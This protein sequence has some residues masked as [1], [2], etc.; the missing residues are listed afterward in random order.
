MQKTTKMKFKRLIALAINLQFILPTASFAKGNTL[1]TIMDAVGTVGGAY[2]QQMQQMQMQEYSRRQKKSLADS[3]KMT[4]VDPNQVPKVFS[5]NGCI[6]VKARSGSTSDM[7]D[8]NKYDPQK[9]QSGYYSALQEISED[10]LEEMKNFLTPGNQRFTTQGVGCFDKSIIQFN[11]ELKLRMAALTNLEKSIEQFAKDFEVDSQPDLEEIK[12]NEALLTGTPAEYLK[13]LK[14]EDEFKDKRCASVFAS[15]QFKSA[16]GKGFNAIETLLNQKVSTDGAKKFDNKNTIKEIKNEIRKFATSLSNSAVTTEEFNVD[17][18]N[19]SIRSVHLDIKNTA[20]IVGEINQK[21]QIENA[22]QKKEIGKIVGSDDSNLQKMLTD[23]ESDSI[24]DL[25]NKIALYERDDNNKCLNGLIESNFKTYKGVTYSSG[26][27]GLKEAIRDPSL[28]EKMNREADSGFE[29]NLGRMLLD[30]N[31]TIEMKLELIKRDS[32]NNNK[33][34]LDLGDSGKIS[35]RSIGA[36]DKLRTSDMIGIFVDNCK[37]IFNKRRTSSGKS[38]KNILKAIKKYSSKRKSLK[39]KYA[40]DL[41]KQIIEKMQ[42]CPEQNTVGDAPNS[43]DGALKMS[44]SNFC[45]KSAVTCSSNMLACQDKAK[46]VVAKHVK[47]QKA[48]VDKYVARV[49]A[50]KFNIE[51]Q[52]KIADQTLKNSAQA[53]SGMHGLGVVYEEP[54]GL[55]MNRLKDK[56]LKGPEFYKELKLEDPKEYLKLVKE[57]IKNL[58]EKV[59]QNHKDLMN[60]DPDAKVEYKGILG[61]SDKYKKNLQDENQLWEDTAKNCLALRNKFDNEAAA[62]TAKENEAIAKSNEEMK[63]TCGKI[64]DFEEHPL[65]F[66]GDVSGF[67]DEVSKISSISEGRSVANVRQFQDVCDH[68]ESQSSNTNDTTGSSNYKKINTKGP[69]D[70][71]MQAVN[72]DFRPCDIVKNITGANKGE[73]LCIGNKKGEEIKNDLVFAFLQSDEGKEIY[74]KFAGK[75]VDKNLVTTSPETNG[76]CKES[77]DIIP[78]SEKSIELANFIIARG[79]YNDRLIEFAD[80]TGGDFSKYVGKVCESDLNSNEQL[81][82]IQVES[83]M[84]ASQTASGLSEL[85]GVKIS[86]C[87]ATMNNGV[88]KTPGYGQQEGAFRDIASGA[89]GLFQ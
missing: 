41:K 88:G 74:D 43:C 32:V 39:R 38:K 63:A 70:Y 59:E 60:G 73:D 65:G 14:L 9:A 42:S 87:N 55:K 8:P 62:A 2:S 77:D 71:C 25:E 19:M 69:Y 18:S 68:H 85:G 17:P 76:K 4:Q 12:K 11:A 79:T 47:V 10:N 16:S 35:G 24:N 51:K 75:C 58:K 49:E 27:E 80:E 50:F 82:L 48:H 37:E 46:N 36:S 54:I 52:F 34:I 31:K 29:N 33:R 57:D 6:V 21:T 7:C 83:Q 15:T 40:Q 3:M 30:S 81:A 45:L 26:I 78:A 23:I 44:S 53:L 28:S 56:F 13:N 1:G 5:Q 20:G 67:A 84:K 86:A 64:R 89:A 61:E 22:Q 66:C 72:K